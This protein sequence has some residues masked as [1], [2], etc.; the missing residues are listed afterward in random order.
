MRPWRQTRAAAMS[1]PTVA[2]I[3]WLV[4][5][6]VIDTEAEAQSGY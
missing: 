6:L 5:A 4:L 2:L 3:V 1:F